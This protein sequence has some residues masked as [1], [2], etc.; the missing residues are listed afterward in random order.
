MRF[1]LIG[2]TEL[3]PRSAWLDQLREASGTRHIVSTVCHDE[4]LVGDGLPDPETVKVSHCRF[5]V[6]RFA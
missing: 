6:I 5:D 3:A 2:E 1:L 4:H